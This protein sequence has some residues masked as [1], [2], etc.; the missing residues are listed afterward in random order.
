MQLTEMGQVRPAMRPTVAL[1]TRELNLIAAI[2][3]RGGPLIWVRHGRG[4]QPVAF[5]PG[6]A[7]AGS[8]A[9]PP[10][11]QTLWD[12]GMLVATA[13]PPGTAGPPQAGPSFEWMAVQLSERGRDVAYRRP[14]LITDW[15][16]GWA[17]LD[18][19]RRPRA[20]EGR[21]P[22]HLAARAVAAMAR[23]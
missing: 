5:F 17:D 15:I 10:L 21:A 20:A 9:L 2:E 13:I 23:A 19:G 3:A 12:A 6:H 14:N 22:A 16:R 8:Q 7:G 11:V 1:G 4:G 18:A